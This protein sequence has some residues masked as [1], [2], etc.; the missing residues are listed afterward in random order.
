VISLVT[1]KSVL[2]GL[3]MFSSTAFVILTD[4]VYTL[5]PL[6]FSRFLLDGLGRSV[7]GLSSW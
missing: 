5:F 6:L 7:F 3:F 1:R 2:D 4:E